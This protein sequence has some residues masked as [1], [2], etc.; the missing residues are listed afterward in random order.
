MALL[1]H[2]RK[3]KMPRYG[4]E[5]AGHSEKKKKE[6]LNFFAQKKSKVSNIIYRCIAAHFEVFEYQVYNRYG[7]CQGFHGYA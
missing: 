2:V 1:G 6:N 5:I 3:V 4:T 7:S